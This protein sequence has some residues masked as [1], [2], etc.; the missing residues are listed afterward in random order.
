MHRNILVTYDDGATRVYDP[1]SAVRIVNRGPRSGPYKD[2]ERV[3]SDPPRWVG[4]GSFEA[5]ILAV[6]HVVETHRGLQTVAEVVRDF[7]APPGDGA[8]SG[9]A[10]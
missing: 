8:S 2:F 7:D 6:G 1:K 5:R 9:T 3:S 4:F 10:R